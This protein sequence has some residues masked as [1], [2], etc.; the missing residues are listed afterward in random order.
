MSQSL[1]YVCEKSVIRPYGYS[2]SKV[3]V[4]GEFPG[5]LEIEHGRPFVA[6]SRKQSAGTVLRQEMAH[7]G[8]DLYQFRMTNLWYHTPTDKKDKNFEACFEASK[9]ACLEEAKGKEAIL[10]VGSDCVE[11]FTGYK[12]SDVSG[13]Q[14]ESNML[15]APIIYAMVQPAIVYHGRGIGEVRFAIENFVNHIRQEGL[16]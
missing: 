9:N 14:V 6:V 2:Q 7:A 3:L 8:A 10:L 16:T 15:S 1:C 5:P 11:F 13:L 4:I 12:V